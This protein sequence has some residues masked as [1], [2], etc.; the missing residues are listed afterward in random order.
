MIEIAINGTVIWSIDDSSLSANQ[1][2]LLSGLITVF[3]TGTMD[4][5]HFSVIK[6]L[7]EAD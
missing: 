7:F 3:I 2:S 1:K 6:E 5:S 4:A